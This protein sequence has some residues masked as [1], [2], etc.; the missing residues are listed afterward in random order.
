MRSFLS[1]AL[2]AAI[3]FIYAIQLPSAEAGGL[4]LWSREISFHPAGGYTLANRFSLRGITQEGLHITGECAYYQPAGQD[5]PTVRIEGTKTGDGKFWPDVTSQ[6]M[7][8]RTGSWE[9]ISKTFNHG[10][11]AVVSVKP[12]EMNGELLIALDIFLPLVDKCKLGRVVLNSGET[13]E[14]DL[15]HLL[16]DESELEA[17]TEK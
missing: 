5:L 13:A 11:R 7:N 4:P 3:C 17:K 8:D 2:Y 16:E 1:P 14:F 12:G 10:H 15:K 9:T 6:V